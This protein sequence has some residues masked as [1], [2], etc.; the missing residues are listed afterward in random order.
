MAGTSGF[1]TAEKF[2]KMG[3]PE[4]RTRQTPPNRTLAFNVACALVYFVHY[5]TELLL[6]TAEYVCYCMLYCF[7]SSAQTVSHVNQSRLMERL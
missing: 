2:E 5:L 7:R 4:L 3:R 6:S 1:T